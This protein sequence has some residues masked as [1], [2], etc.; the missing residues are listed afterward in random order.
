MSLLCWGVIVLVGFCGF[1]NVMGRGV[2]EVVNVRLRGKE[3]VVE[4]DNEGEV[5]GD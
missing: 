5:D 3:K 1:W 4:L 2:E